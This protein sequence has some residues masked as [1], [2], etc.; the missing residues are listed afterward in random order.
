MKLNIYGKVAD[1]AT[2]E[3]IE[4]ITK[5]KAFENS[6]VAIM[7]DNHM[8]KGACVGFTATFEDKIIPNVVGVDVGCGMAMLALPATFT[9]SQENLQRLQNAIRKCVPHG[10]KVREEWYF[11]AYQ[12]LEF[13][14]FQLTEKQ[15]VHIMKSF[16]TLGGG[17]HF[18]ELNES[19]DGTLYLVVHSGSRNL[20]QLVARHHQAIAEKNFVTTRPT[21][22]QIEAIEPKLRAEFIAGFGTPLVNDTPTKGLEY[23]VGDQVED[24]LNDMRIAQEFAK[25]NRDVI[26]Y[27]I[28]TELFDKVVSLDWLSEKIT[29]TIHNYIDIENKIIRKGAIFAD[30]NNDIIIPLNMRDGSIIARGIGNKEANF[31]APHGAGRVMSRTVAKEKISLEDF[32]ETMKD[33]V[34]WTVNKNTLDEAP[35]AYKSKEEIVGALKELVNIKEIIKPVFNFKDDSNGGRE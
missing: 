15:H 8:G 6:N 33:V 14:T 35:F 25:T 26:I 20:G 34:S 16:G 27:E 23:L 12:E 2:Q 3:Q 28:F 22:E 11:S 5:S 19:E 30:E 10:M 4:N 1:Q 31:S 32:K 18:I 24:Y 13:L 7:P 9:K 17:N 21:K 29:H